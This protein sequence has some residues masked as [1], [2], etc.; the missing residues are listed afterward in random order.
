MVISNSGRSCI[1]LEAFFPGVLQSLRGHLKSL[2]AA[3]ITVVR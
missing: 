2:F 1:Y 3:V